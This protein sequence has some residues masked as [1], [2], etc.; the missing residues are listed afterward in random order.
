MKFLVCY[1][2]SEASKYALKIALNHA[3]VWDAQLL[4]VRAITRVEPL[5]HTRVKKK[6]EEL[7]SEVNKFIGDVDI[8][9]TS[10]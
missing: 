5:K 4:V 8:P 1:D 3:K 10:S 9:V 6:E 7:E 2:G